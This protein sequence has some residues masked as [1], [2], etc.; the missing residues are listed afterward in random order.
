MK[1]HTCIFTPVLQLTLCALLSSAAALPTLI[2]LVDNPPLQTA[3]ATPTSTG[4]VPLGTAVPFRYLNIVLVFTN[5][6]KGI[7]RNEVVDTLAGADRIATDYLDTEPEEAIPQ[8]R[9]EYRLPQGNVLLVIGGPVEK[10]ITWRQLYRVLQALIRFM[11]LL[12]PPSGP[13]YQELNFDIQISDGGGTLGSGVIWYFPDPEDVQNGTIT[14]PVLAVPNGS[15]L[16]ERTISNAVLAASGSSLLAF[17]ESSNLTLALGSGDDVLYPITGTSMTLEFYYFGLGLPRALVTANLEG[18]LAKAREYSQ[19]PFENYTIKN[20]RFYLLT[21][22]ATYRIASTVYPLNGHQITWLELFHVLDGLRQFVFGIN[23]EN[24][25]FQMLGYRILDNIQGKIGVGTL[26]YYDP[27]PPPAIDRRAIP[28]GEGSPGSVLTQIAKPTNQTFLSVIEDHIPDR[29]PWRI[30]ETDLTL[31]FTVAGREVPVVELLALLA[32]TQLRIAANVTATPDGPIGNFRYQNGPGTLV[33]SFLTYKRMIITWLNLHRILVGLGQFCAEEGHSRAWGFQIST[34]IQGTVGFGVVAPDPDQTPIQRRASGRGFLSRSDS[35]SLSPEKM[36]AIQR[37]NPI[38]PVPGTPITLDFAYIGSTAISPIDLTA[39]LTSAL[40]KIEPHLMHESAQAIPESQWAYRDWTTRV[41]FGIKVHPGRTL[42]WQQL[43]WIIIGVLQWMTGPGINDCKILAFDVE[44][45]GQEGYVGIGSVIQHRIPDAVVKSRDPASLFDISPLDMGNVGKRNLVSRNSL[46]RRA[47]ESP[48][49]AEEGIVPQS[50]F[51]SR[52]FSQIATHSISWSELDETLRGLQS[53]VTRK[54]TQMLFRQSLLSKRDID[55]AEWSTAQGQLGHTA[56]L[57]ETLAARSVLPSNGTNLI[58]L[59]PFPIPGTDIILRITLLS[60]AIPASRLTDIFFHARLAIETTTQRFP[61]VYYDRAV[62]R[63]EVKYLNFECIAIEVHIERGE[64]LTWLEL[65]QT[66]NGLQ[67]I[68]NGAFRQTVVFTI[69]INQES[70]ASGMLYYFPPQPTSTLESRSLS[71]SVLSPTGTNLTAPIPYPIPN[72]DITLRI[73]VLS[74]AI[75]ASRL[76]DIFYHARLAL[77]P[78][79]RRHPNEDYDKDVFSTQIDYFDGPLIAIK[80]YPQL[81]Q[82]LTWLQL[83]HSVNG[84]QLFL[85]GAE[86]GPSTVTFKV[87]VNGVYVAYGLLIY[88]S[89]PPTSTFKTRSLPPSNAVLT[90]TIPYPLIGTPITLVFTS[91]L[92]TP[93]PIERLIEFFNLAFNEVGK[94]IADH[95]PGSSTRLNWIFRQTFAPRGEISIT[96]RRV[97]GRS[98]TWVNLAEVLEGVW[99]FMEGKWRPTTSLQALAFNVE[100]VER[101]VVASG[102]LSYYSGLSELEEVA[103]NSSISN[104]TSLS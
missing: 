94:D 68:L 61:H 85:D 3:S 53:F 93:I 42:S 46:E 13:H 36:T 72:T 63:Q 66:I 48:N 29:I 43:N 69:E 38:Y 52:W 10:E 28:D 100:I 44:I 75:P 45:M 49:P 65:N 74:R 83:Y 25:H 87:E 84:L 103:G 64:H 40:H 32:A 31:T 97:I 23:E 88:I 98:M 82:H 12:K 35:T 79:A 47:A 59:D 24:T 99:D 34:T 19:G 102:E 4:L 77:L 73:T 16:Q 56:Y 54:P 50:D 90:D 39:A 7:P 1:R 62:F 81:N 95:R 14:T 60:R 96:I 101:G 15:L 8:N 21:G 104:S 20:N 17:N 41:S 30:P 18:A 57:P 11:T 5:F 71:R 2:S 89:P 9:F 67:N 91:L 22:G 27:G 76:T 78:T 70:V 86:G 80:V 51:T 6:G 92:P 58:D 37:R 33:I 55:M 26:A